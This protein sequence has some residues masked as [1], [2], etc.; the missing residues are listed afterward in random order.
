LDLLQI[1]LNLLGHIIN[2]QLFK[3]IVL[4]L[5][6]NHEKFNFMDFIVVRVRAYALLAA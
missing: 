5:G 4:L 6:I 2:E 1:G 3:E